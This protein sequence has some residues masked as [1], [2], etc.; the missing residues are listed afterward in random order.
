[1]KAKKIAALC[2]ASVLLL[3]G[4]GGKTVDGKSVVASTSEGNVYAD[5]VYDTLISTSA[6]KSAAFQYVLD[7]LINK[8][9]PV[10]SDMKV[11]E[12][13][14]FNTDYQIMTKSSIRNI[15]KLTKQRQ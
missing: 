10:T 4:C 6:G 15:I 13:F 12:I 3:S 11:H 5:D 14:G 9:Y 7:Q 8:Q 2:L 1:M